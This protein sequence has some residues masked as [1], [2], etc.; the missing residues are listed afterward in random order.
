[1]MPRKKRK[2]ILIVSIISIVAIIAM[3]L[4]FLYI[5]TDSFKSSRTLFFRYIGQN[6]ENWEAMYPEKEKNEYE[7]LL[8]QN[9]YTT[10]TEVTVNYTENVGTD[11]ENKE[12]VINQLKL[13]V[14]GQ[15]DN[16]KQYNYQDIHL[17][18]NNEKLSELEYIQSGEACGIR[19]P[20]LFSQY[21]VANREEAKEILLKVG[22]E[23]EI[24]NCIEKIDFGDFPTLTK[25][26]QQ[27]VKNKYLNLLNQNVSDENFSKQKNQTIQIDGKTINVNA[28]SLTLTKEKMNHIYLKM[29]EEIKQDEIILQKIDDLQ[30]WLEPYQVE[31]NLKEKFVQN[32]D[33]LIENITRNNIGQEKAQITVYENYHTTVRTVI[34]NPDYEITI[35]LLSLLEENYAQISY[36]NIKDKKKQVISYKKEG[37]QISIGFENTQREKTKKYYFISNQKVSGNQCVKN[38]DFLY[39]DDSNKVEATMKQE[40]NIVDIAEEDV[41]QKEENFINLSDLEEEQLQ[42]ILEQAKAKVSEETAKIKENVKEDE[43]QKVFKVV[44]LIRENQNFEGTGIT[45]TE[46][47]RFNAKF[48]ILQGEKLEN[49]AVLNLI[50]A[51]KDNL[52]DFEVVS[53]TELKLKI[54]R[55]R[56]KEE[57]VTTL[58]TFMEENKKQNYNVR[59]DYDETT[60]LVSGIILTRVVE[61]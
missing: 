7:K 51:I 55:L 21:L 25:A 1:M 32:I 39:E 33:D 22:E 16:S 19:F 54:D 59:V 6:V 56:N 24:G 44:G 57:V 46:K 50:D 40:I 29:L 45:E 48:E 61:E 35:D 53:G 23:E 43:I 5:T 17:L 15:T 49:E 14:K 30:T 20:D 41:I 12:N 18:K 38:K 26:E 4:I 8:E 9:K 42:A 28:Y 3:T 36:Q 31:T 10:D 37:E 52:I 2:I 11:L 13:E 34:E 47:K 60:G 58:T 27:T